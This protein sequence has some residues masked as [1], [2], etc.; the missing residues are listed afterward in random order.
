MPHSRPDPHRMLR[1]AMLLALTLA[2]A[3]AS[4]TAAVPPFRKAEPILAGRVILPAATFV[5]GPTSGQ[6]IAGANGVTPPFIARQPVQGFSA[7]LP[8]PR[9]GTW[10][11]MSDNGFGAKANSADAL[12]RVHAVKLDF[13]RGAVA[14]VDVINGEPLPEFNGRSHIQLRDP[15][16][17]IPFPIVADADTYPGTR[18]AVDGEIRVGRLLT[19]ADFDIESMR[20]APDGTLWFG[21]EFGPFLLHTDATGRVLEAPIPLPNTLG[22][23]ANPWVQAPENPLRPANVPANLGGSKGFEGM[24]LDWTGRTLYTLLEGALTDDPLR[25]RLLINEFDLTRRQYTAGTLAYRLESPSHAI[26]D[27]TAIAPHRFIVIERDGGQGASARF[28]KLYRVDM[29][30]VDADGFVQKQEIADLLDLHDPLQ[31]GGADTRNSRFSFPF[32]TIEDVIPVDSRTLLVINDN[33]F[34]FSNGRT[35]GVADNNEFILVRMARSL[36]AD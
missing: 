14:P 19:G 27:F 22:I 26:G 29:R 5:R 10:L 20:R 17:R 25:T 24:A 13:A 28:K 16:R 23:G 8:G 6:F 11:V 15:D 7:V 31:I 2:F 33:N 34:P 18:L 32:V 3:G 30:Q 4:A 35:P 21:D 12:L 36:T 1:Q 9:R